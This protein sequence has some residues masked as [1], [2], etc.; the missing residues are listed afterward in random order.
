MDQ[1]NFLATQIVMVLGGVFGGALGIFLFFKLAVWTNK[2]IMRVGIVGNHK[3]GVLYKVALPKYRHQSDTPNERISHVKSKSNVAEQMF[4]EL[5]G[6]VPSDW[7]KHLIYRENLS[8]EIV[9]D[10]NEINFYVFCSRNIADFVRNTIY[11]A[12][13]EAEILEV[14]DYTDKLKDHVNRGYVRMVGPE[15]APIRTFDTLVTDSL[16]SML[17]KMVNLKGEEVVAVQY[18][19]TP[20]SG[21]WRKRAYSYLNYLKNKQNKEYVKDTG[22]PGQVEVNL[23]GKGTPQ[24]TIDKDAYEGVEKKMNK[25]GY[26]VGIR[27][28]SSAKDMMTSR[29]NFDL[30]ARSFVQFDVPPLASFQPSQFWMADWNFLRDYKLRIQPFIDWPFF[31]QQFIA[32]TE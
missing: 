24:V 14:P 2:M 8:F 10:A 12:Y 27:I 30:L 7:R 19:V 22:V 4:A 26:L 6:I 16:N 20:V 11:G 29:S 28:M 23:L 15:Y 9:A 18:Y 5:R 3:R 31:K 21:S 25:K 17:N 13:P 1:L 32:N